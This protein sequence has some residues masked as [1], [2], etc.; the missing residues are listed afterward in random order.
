MTLHEIRIILYVATNSLA[1][2]AGFIIGITIIFDLDRSKGSL[3]L[4]IAS[5]LTVLSAFPLAILMM[6]SIF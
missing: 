5:G 3:Y 1:F 2:I 6:T 4:K